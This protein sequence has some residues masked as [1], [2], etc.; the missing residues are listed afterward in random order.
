MPPLQVIDFGS[1]CH[2]TKK[3]FKYIQSRFYRSPEVILGLPYD[4]AIDMWSLVCCLGGRC[5]AG[6]RAGILGSQECT[7]FIRN[8]GCGIRKHKHAIRNWTCRSWTG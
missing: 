2:L 8:Q 6:I 1:S 3:M 7:K 5:P 4:C